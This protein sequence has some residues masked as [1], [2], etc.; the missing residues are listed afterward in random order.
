MP[1]TPLP[2]PS[3]AGA[4]W[5]GRYTCQKPTPCSIASPG[6]CLAGSKQTE[7]T[8]MLFMTWQEPQESIERGLAYGLLCFA[9][10]CEMSGQLAE[11]SLAQKPAE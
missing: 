2:P 7:E 4:S 9:A 6:V 3:E 8:C 1:Y 5:P 10:L 11:S